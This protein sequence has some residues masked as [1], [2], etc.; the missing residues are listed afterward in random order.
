MITAKVDYNN[1]VIEFTELGKCTYL[2]RPARRLQHVRQMTNTPIIKAN[3]LPI[4]ST[5]IIP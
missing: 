5:H 2:D 1:T 3:F 4:I